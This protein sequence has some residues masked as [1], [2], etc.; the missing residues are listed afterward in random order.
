[1]SRRA[2][3]IAIIA[4]G[5]MDQ[6][7]CLQCHTGLLHPTCGRRRPLPPGTYGFRP[8]GSGGK[9]AMCI[10]PAIGPSRHIST[11]DIYQATGTARVTAGYGARVTG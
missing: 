9:G 3:M 11:F 10:R 5:T 7:V 8:D 6:K 4:T 2:G 1:M